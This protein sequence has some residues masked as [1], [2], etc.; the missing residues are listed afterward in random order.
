MQNKGNMRLL[1]CQYSTRLTW[2]YMTILAVPRRCEESK[3]QDLPAVLFSAS[4]FFWHY[5]VIC[6]KI[7]CEM[8]DNGCFVSFFEGKCLYYNY[9]LYYKCCTFESLQRCKIWVLVWQLD[10]HA[11]TCTQND[12]TPPTHTHTRVH[13]SPRSGHCS[14]WRTK[15]RKASTSL[16]WKV[17]H[18]LLIWIRMKKNCS[19]F[20][21][22]KW[23][24]AK[25]MRFL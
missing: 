15:A 19:I 24:K 3:C 7:L 10:A 8:I 12:R 4:T 25:H 20:M 16:A 2:Q 17:C 6:N 1:S 21:A 13:T 14:S 5:L 22:R 18:I 9:S 11:H 23:T